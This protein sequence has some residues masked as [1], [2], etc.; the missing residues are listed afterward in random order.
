[1]RWEVSEFFSSHAFLYKRSLAEEVLE[2]FKQVDASAGQI[3][4]VCPMSYCDV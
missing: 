1:M 4:L 2:Y 3:R